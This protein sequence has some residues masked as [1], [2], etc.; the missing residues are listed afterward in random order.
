MERLERAAVLLSLAE[1]LRD[2]GSWCGETHLQKGTYFLQELPSLP[3][4]FDFILYKHGPFSFDLSDEIS[5]MRVNDFLKWQ[6]QQWPYGPKLI[7][8]ERAELLK[9]KYQ[10]TM[11][12]YV[13]KVEKMAAELASMGVRKLERY[14]TAHYVSKNNTELDAVDIPA[15]IVALKPHIDIVEAQEAVAFVE[16]LKGGWSDS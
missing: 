13:D 1:N 10:E 4:G 3:L 11:K 14:A 6:P 12:K 5:W 9:Q 7:P 16:Q 2:G 8:G 15:K